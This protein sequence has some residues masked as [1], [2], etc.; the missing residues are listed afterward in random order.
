MKKTIVIRSNQI[1]PDPRVEKI[2]ESLCE[3]GFEV[4][5]LSWNRNDFNLADVEIKTL[6]SF[7]YKIIR[8][9]IPAQF[10]GGL[11]NLFPL[12]LWQIFLVYWLVRNRV[13]YEL[14]Y[15]C[16]FDTVLPAVLM[17][18]IFKK[19]L[20]YDIFDYYVDSFRVPNIFKPIIRK[21]D[22][23]SM[24]ACDRLIICDENRIEQIAF[25]DLRKITII[26]NSPKDLLPYFNED[27]E[28]YYRK[29]NNFTLSYVG[30]LQEGRFIAE[31]IDIFKRNINWNLLIGGF[32][33]LEEY[34]K[35]NVTANITF[36]GKLSYIQAMRLYYESDAIFA[37]YD[38]QIP[39][40]KFSSPNK[41][42][43][44][45]M[46][47]KPIIVAKGTGIDKFVEKY[48]IG[49]SVNYYDVKEVEEAIIKLSNENYR[50]E[51]GSNGR[52][53]YEKEYK[54][55]KLKKRLFD[56]IEKIYETSSHIR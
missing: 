16:D 35:K 34:I 51:L 4:V 39:N 3:A 25:N 5:V 21:L 33:P 46:L 24:I 43:E 42:F 9:R 7:K 17:K 8:K 44:A 1:N 53:L 28:F 31:M 40:H 41:V 10:G 6:N 27:N 47:A 37:I 30:I 29:N 55:E 49:L 13:N 50:L 15:A 11:R 12:L 56:S 36:L 20:I 38:P 19:K 45:M 26:P 22:K 32:G 52:N 54:W 14:I 2:A 23:W 18:L 48:K